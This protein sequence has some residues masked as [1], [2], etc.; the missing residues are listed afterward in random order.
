MYISP[1][2]TSQWYVPRHTHK[3]TCQ[4]EYDVRTLT[5]E[6]AC[7]EVLDGNVLEL[8]RLIAAWLARDHVLAAEPRAEPAQVTVAVERV[9]Q[10]VPV[11]V[12]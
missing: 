1:H 3:D 5:R 12:T 10:Q 2:D 8:L 4:Y 7:L 6:V 9:L 11:V